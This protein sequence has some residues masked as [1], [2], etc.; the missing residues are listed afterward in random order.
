MS[1]FI[2]TKYLRKRIEDFME[3]SKPTMEYEE[4]FG[5]GLLYEEIDK[6]LREVE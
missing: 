4:Y 5:M 2:D 1:R 3:K 6:I